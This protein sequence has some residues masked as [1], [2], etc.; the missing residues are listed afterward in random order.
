MKHYSKTCKHKFLI[1]SCCWGFIQ[2]K[3]AMILNIFPHLC[4]ACSSAKLKALVLCYMICFFVFFTLCSFG[5]SVRFVVI[6]SS[7]TSPFSLSRFP[8]HSLGFLTFSSS[9]WHEHV[10]FF[11]LSLIFLDYPLFSLFWLLVFWA[12]CCWVMNPRI[13][14]CWRPRI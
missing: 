14:L 2:Y 12:Q 4:L 3:L 1:S 10:A 5:L 11:F 6:S 7:L 13:D 8:I 9:S